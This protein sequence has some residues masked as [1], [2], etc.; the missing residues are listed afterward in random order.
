MRK[1]EILLQAIV[2]SYINAKK[3]MKKEILLQVIV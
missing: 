3:M 1:K 2:L